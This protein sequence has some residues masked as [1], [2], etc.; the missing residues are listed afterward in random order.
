MESVSFLWNKKEVAQRFEKACNKLTVHF[1][2]ASVA[3]ST[4]MRLRRF[5]CLALGTHRK[6]VVCHSLNFGR[7]GRCGNRTGVC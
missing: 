7:H 5:E 3:Y 2:D 4:M 6:F 1:A